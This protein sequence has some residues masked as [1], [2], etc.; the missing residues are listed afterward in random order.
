MNNNYESHTLVLTNEEL[1]VI[2]DALSNLSYKS[3]APIIGIL[4]SQ[5]QAEL[6]EKK[7]KAE[8]EAKEDK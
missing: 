8:E 6:E 1:S 2:F 4:Q 3:A 7:K 5:L